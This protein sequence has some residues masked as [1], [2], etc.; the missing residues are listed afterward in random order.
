MTRPPIVIRSLDAGA[1]RRQRRS[2]AVGLVVGVLILAA[3]DWL[4]FVGLTQ[5][6]WR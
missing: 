6:A 5:E 4:A 2:R 3:V 1:L